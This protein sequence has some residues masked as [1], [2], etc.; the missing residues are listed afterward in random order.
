[1]VLTVLEVALI[2]RSVRN[3]PGIVACSDDE[4]FVLC[5]VA[6]EDPFDDLGVGLK[7]ADGVV[8]RWVLADVVR[9]IGELE[10]FNLHRSEVLYD[11]AIEPLAQVDRAS[12]VP[13]AADAGTYCLTRWHIEDGLEGAETLGKL[14]RDVLV[15]HLVI[16]LFRLFDLSIVLIGSLVI[17]LITL[18]EL[19]WLHQAPVD[20]LLVE[21]LPDLLVIDVG[22]L[23]LVAQVIDHELED[24]RVAVDK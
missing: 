17:L 7:S 23:A 1:M 3:L 10:F 20:E 16:L 2:Y 11:V 5:K 15:G 13:E 12:L 14:A 8:Y 22:I 24:C 18:L 4:L 6:A 9:A 21:A 19:L